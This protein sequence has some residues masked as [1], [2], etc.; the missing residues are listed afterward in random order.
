MMRKAYKSDLTD[1]QWQLIE[2][3]IPTAKPGGRR[4]EA[5]TYAAMVRLMLNR[6]TS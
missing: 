3:L 4:R 1:A 6:L 5:M 2:P